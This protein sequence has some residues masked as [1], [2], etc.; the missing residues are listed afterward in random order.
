MIRFITEAG[1][2]LFGNKDSAALKTPPQRVAES[3]AARYATSAQVT[4]ANE[5]HFDETARADSASATLDKCYGD[6]DDG[7]L[8]R[9]DAWLYSP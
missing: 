6:S 1:G 5:P 4:P 3:D 7:L 8:S 9:Q 2:K